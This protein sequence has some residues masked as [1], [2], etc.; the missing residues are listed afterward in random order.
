MQ[1]QAR[2]QCLKKTLIEKKKQNRDKKGDEPPS[3]EIS[4]VGSNQNQKVLRN[5]STDI[6]KKKIKEIYLKT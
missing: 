4:F 1:I 5:T 2:S 6:L 3:A